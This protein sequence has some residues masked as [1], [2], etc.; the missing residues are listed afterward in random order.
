MDL[1][2]VRRLLSDLREMR[3]HERWTRARLEAYQ[4]EALR[5]LRD[6]AYTRSPF[7]RRFHE[8]L[9]GRPLRELP[10][11][12]K[13]MVMEHFDDLV[14]DRAVRLRDVRE[15]MIRDREGNRFA[16]RYWVTAT[17]GSTGEPGV[18]LFDRD[19][20]RVPSPRWGV[21]TSGP[22]YR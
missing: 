21:S 22:A 7:Y 4:A 3:K 9:F 16:D 2:L 15:H 11:L 1:Q 14:T 19:E 10:V 8:G 5:R 12:T 6:H 18:F 13:A 17:S 20:W